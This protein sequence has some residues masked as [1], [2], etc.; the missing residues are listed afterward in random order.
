LLKELGWKPE[1]VDY[2]ENNEAFAVNSFLLHKYLNVPYEKM[3]VHG[4]A[5]AIGHPLGMSGARITLELIN[6][7]ETHG[8]KRGIAAICHGLGGAAALALEL[9]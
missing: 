3:N 7:L 1:D 4:G 9:V 2:W 6:V 5:I 8:G